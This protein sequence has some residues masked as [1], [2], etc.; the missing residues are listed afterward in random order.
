MGS[1]TNLFYFGVPP[2]S[3]IAGSNSTSIGTCDYPDLGYRFGNI[4]LFMEGIPRAF[5]QRETTLI[6]EILID[7]YN[8]VSGICTDVYQREMLNAK[9]IEQIH[10]PEL[11]GSVDMLVCFPFV[12]VLFLVCRENCV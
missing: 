8:D 9:L 12:G 2:A 10:Y 1:K 7:A 5:T 6:E 11:L 4:T 3:F